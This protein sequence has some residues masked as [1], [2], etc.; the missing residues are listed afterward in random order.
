MRSFRLLFFGG[1]AR[2]LR[3]GDRTSSSCSSSSSFLS[4]CSS[5]SRNDAVLKRRCATITTTTRDD[6]FLDDESNR[7]LSLYARLP[8]RI[9]RAVAAQIPRDL[10]SRSSSSSGVEK[11]KKQKTVVAIALSGGVDSF[12]SAWLLKN[13]LL[14]EKNNKRE[15]LDD[16]ELKAILMKNWDEREETNSECQFDADRRSAEKLAK[17][18][19]LPLH[20]VDF[21]REYWQSVFSPFTESVQR[22]ETPNPDVWCNREIKFGKLLEHVKRGEIGAKYLVT[23]HYAEV[24]REYGDDDTKRS[25]LKRVELRRAKD[26][27]KDQTYFLAS[28]PSKALES[29]I[30]PLAELTKANDVVELI[31]REVLGNVANVLDRKSSAGICFVGKKRNF[32]DFV[33]EYVQRD[34]AWFVDVRCI[35]S[36]NSSSGENSRLDS[37]N[38]GS[39]GS[40]SGRSSISSIS[41]STSGSQRRGLDVKGECDDIDEKYILGKCESVHSVTVGQRA[42]IGGLP[43]PYFVVGKSTEEK[44]SSKVY[45]CE[46]GDHPALLTNWC[47]IKDIHFVHDD[48]DDTDALNASQ[49]I[50]VKTRYASPLVPATMEKVPSSNASEQQEREQEQQV[51]VFCR[52]AYEKATTTTATS[53]SSSLQLTTASSSSSSSSPSPPPTFL[54]ITFASPEKAV[55]IGQAVVMYHQSTSRVLGV[56][57][58]AYHGLTVFEEKIKE[59]KRE[60]K[61]KRGVRE[62]QHSRVLERSKMRARNRDTDN[63]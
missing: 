47:V 16:I 6:H 33:H 37:S 44:G 21:C 40:S 56:G 60:E 43:N 7:Q 5:S 29:V 3:S 50:R 15:N 46:G 2:F 20:E 38:R 36:E 19:S 48:E 10:V 61:R 11:K 35:K 55:S 52:S 17:Y 18:L 59:E 4:N 26:E 9:K 8:E 51:S 41:N 57:S 13:A 24:W 27:T 32:S 53:S 58:V 23:G 39:I 28:V 49:Q 25:S 12:V 62:Q 31:A 1:G 30:F 63:R 54:R 42:R 34:P 22:G 45:L 14:L